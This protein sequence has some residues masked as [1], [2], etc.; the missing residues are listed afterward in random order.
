[1]GFRSS[2][3]KVF[4][5]TQ[6]EIR[7]VLFLSSTF[8]A[9]LGLRWFQETSF[10]DKT[11]VAHFD[12]S[13][14]DS[15][16]ADR[17]AR[18]FSEPAPEGKTARR[19]AKKAV[20][21]HSIDINTASKNDLMLLPGIGESYAERILI[22]RQDNGPFRSVDDLTRVKGIGK[23]TLARIREFIRPIGTPSGEVEPKGKPNPPSKP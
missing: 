15:L 18:V 21:R 8:L 4:G 7:A 19:E 23:R 10:S 12:Y 3:Q 6:N 11:G 1:M 9:G 16:F 5:F 22:D 2:L 17:S 14:Q 13:L 20:A